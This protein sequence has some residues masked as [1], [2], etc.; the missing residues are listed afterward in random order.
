MRMDSQSMRKNAKDIFD[1]TLL[2]KQS[3][4]LVIWILKNG[5]NGTAEVLT[6]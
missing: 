3:K 6:N 5:D 4:K 1:K 2:P